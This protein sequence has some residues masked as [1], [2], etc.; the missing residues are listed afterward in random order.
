[1]EQ[2]SQVLHATQS[3]QR[4]QLEKDLRKPECYLGAK[5]AEASYVME[6]SFLSSIPPSSALLRLLLCIID[7]GNADSWV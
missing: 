6:Y 5:G 3:S 4:T 7:R 2:E 1:M